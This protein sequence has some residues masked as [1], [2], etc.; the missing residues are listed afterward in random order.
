[1]K[2]VKEFYKMIKK[3]TSALLLGAVLVFG[4]SA[5]VAAPVLIDVNTNNGNDTLYVGIPGSIQ[6][7]VNSNGNSV[8]G[9]VWAYFMNFTGGNWIG[10]LSY[11]DDVDPINNVVDGPGAAGFATKAF[12]P[13]Y[14]ANPTTTDTLLFGFVSFG[15]PFTGNSEFFR[16]NVTASGAGSVDF[17]PVEQPD[18]IPPANNFGVQDPTGGDLPDDSKTETIWA[19]VKPNI[20]PVCTGATGPGTVVFG[21]PASGTLS[22]ND[23]DASPAALTFVLVSAVN[24]NAT[25]PNSPITVVGNTWTHNTSNSNTDDVGHWT[26]TFKAYDGLDQSSSD[27]V[28]EYDVISQQPLICFEFGCAEAFSGQDICIPLT[29]TDYFSP[30]VQLGGF[31]LLF[32]YD[33]SMLTFKSIDITGSILESQGWEYLTY[34]VVSASW[35]SPT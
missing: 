10:V 28:V 14:G 25:G 19:V 11:N 16:L 29:V 23:P 8:Q 5:A 1:M 9:V 27:C 18:V 33:A 35:P 21:N 34:R 15:G 17:V 22:G 30:C 7:S 26:L 20:A 32:K 31:D 12:N 3:L 6:F 24:S 4:A 13:G 2:Q